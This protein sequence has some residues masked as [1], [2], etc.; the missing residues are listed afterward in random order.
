M[1]IFGIGGAELILILI[2]MLVVAGPKRMIRWAYVLGKYIAMLQKMWGEAAAMIQKEFDAAGVDVEVP[3]NIP[4]K[5]DLQRTVVKAIKPVSQ[6]F[7]DIKQEINKDLSSV[8]DTAKQ[9]NTALRPPMPRPPASVTRI[10]APTNGTP[11]APSAPPD[12]PNFGT[13]AAGS[14]PEDKVE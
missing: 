5:A 6:P 14:S 1:N 7:D 10:P 11:P 12:V 4:T 8:R 9:A 13:W 3:K 2:I